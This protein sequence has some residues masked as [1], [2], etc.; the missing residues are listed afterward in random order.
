MACLL[1]LHR[2]ALVLNL[3]P[4]V[5]CMKLSLITVSLPML[6]VTIEGWL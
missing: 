3:D 6:Q 1:I 2:T 5:N 4:L